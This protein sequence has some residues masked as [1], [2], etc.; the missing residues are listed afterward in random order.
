MAKIKLNLDPTDTPTYKREVSIPTPD[1][2]PLKIEFEFLHRTREEMA[3]LFDLYI[4]READRVAHGSPEGEQ[5]SLVDITREAL[6]RDVDTTLDVA[7]GWNVDGYEFGKESL[8]LLFARYPA[9]ATAI[10]TDYRVSH[11][12]GR[13]GN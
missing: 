7:V 12:E 8:M 6:A 5:R 4:K 9:A 2:K 3:T 11:T 10:A 13:L 1:G